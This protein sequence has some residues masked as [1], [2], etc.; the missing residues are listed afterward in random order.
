[1][2]HESEYFSYQLHKKVDLQINLTISCKTNL[3]IQNNLSFVYIFSININ[4][5]VSKGLLTHL[6]F[7][8]AEGE[9]GI[10]SP[11]SCFQR[12]LESLSIK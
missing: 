2:S 5:I 4:T 1:M 3:K 7:C 10:C 9:M 8:E 6:H 11:H 12:F